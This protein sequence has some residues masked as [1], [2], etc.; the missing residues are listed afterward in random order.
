MK[1]GKEGGKGGLLFGFVESGCHVVEVNDLPPFVDVFCP[2]VFID[3]I[4]RMFPDVDAEEDWEL[5]E[6]HEVL[7]FNL[8]EDELV[9]GV[10]VE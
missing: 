5:G 4:V 8:G 10:V 7:L 6:V 3:Q 9:G 1:K 2:V